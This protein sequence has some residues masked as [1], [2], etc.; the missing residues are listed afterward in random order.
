M[1]DMERRQEH[2]HTGPVAGEGA[3]TS[4]WMRQC[5]SLAILGL[6][7][8]SGSLTILG[9]PRTSVSIYARGVPREIK[10]FWRERTGTISDGMYS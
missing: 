7:R 5:G 8:T 4:R 6:P 3:E 2:E 1:H 10:E 9:L